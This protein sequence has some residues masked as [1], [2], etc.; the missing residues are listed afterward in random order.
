MLPAGSWKYTA[1]ASQKSNAKTVS[2]SARASSSTRSPSHARAA[3]KRSP[4]HE[5]REVVERIRAVVGG[6][7]LEHVGADR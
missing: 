2:P 4:G 5:Q 1:R 3:S 6:D 7:E